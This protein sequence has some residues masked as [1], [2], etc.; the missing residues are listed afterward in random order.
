MKIKRFFE[1]EE[2]SYPLKVSSDEFFRKRKLHKMCDF[3]VSER[4]YM[5]TELRKKIISYSLSPDFIE[6]FPLH[7]S[8]EIIKLD[9]YWF[10]IS[11][12][13]SR[14]SDE[15]YICDE[16]DEVKVFINSLR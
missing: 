13:Y 1:S 6:I 12:Q 15:Y 10:T 16:F 14:G 8:I 7:R 3:S 2:I 9:D 4:S 11:V 5:A